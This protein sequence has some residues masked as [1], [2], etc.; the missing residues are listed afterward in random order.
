[1]QIVQDFSNPPLPLPF[2]PIP[3]LERYY[4]LDFILLQMSHGVTTTR[5]NKQS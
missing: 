4:H 3:D 2:P 1:L 5:L